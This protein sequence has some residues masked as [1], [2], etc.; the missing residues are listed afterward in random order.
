MHSSLP[1]GP[2]F[3]AVHRV[4][5]D[6]GVAPV[7][8]ERRLDRSAAA[9]PRIPGIAEAAEVHGV[10]DRLHEP[11]RARVVHRHGV[12]VHHVLGGHVAGA[13][14]RDR[15]RRDVPAQN[16][17]E[18]QPRLVRRP[19]FL[20][21]HGFRR[22]RDDLRLRDGLCGRLDLFGVAG[23]PG[24]RRPRDRRDQAQRNGRRSTAAAPN[25][26]AA[27]RSG[28]P[29]W[30]PGHG[31]GKRTAFASYSTTARIC[32]A[33]LVQLQ[34]STAAARAAVRSAS[35]SVPR[36]ASTA[37]SRSRSASTSPLGKLARPARPG[38]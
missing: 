38:G 26:A 12:A 21:A 6:V 4:V 31:G 13:G 7:R 9:R 16:L 29:G 34:R 1:S 24:H 32:L 8:R 30:A 28:L 14:R 37:S 3:G 2:K 22:R 15:L 35:L 5:G 17:A 19:R 11:E 27:L 10:G 36:S 18:L 33:T 23:P 25:L 20:L